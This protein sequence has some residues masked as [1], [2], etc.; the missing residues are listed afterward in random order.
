M[1]VN[2]KPNQNEYSNI[3]AFRFW[4]QK[5]IPLVYEDTLSYYEL[6]SKVVNY[7]NDT[8]K[9]V[10]LMGDDMNKLYTAYTQLHDYVSTYFD[11]LSVQNEVDYKLDLMATDGT[12]S[13]LIQPLFDVYK[14]QIDGIILNQNELIRSE[15]D[16]Q[17]NT[18]DSIDKSCQEQEKSYHVLSGR[19]DTFTSLPNGSTTGDA[20]LLDLR[21]DTDG[22]K[23]NSAGTSVRTQIKKLE[24][25]LFLKRKTYN[26]LDIEKISYPC[27]LDGATGT[28]TESS[29]QDWILNWFTSDFIPCVYG[30]RYILTAY[31]PTNSWNKKNIL[32]RY[33]THIG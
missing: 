21:V 12:L 10:G 33:K 28:T 7:L 19:M 32:V 31:S 29:D 16:K 18:I 26:A 27:F 9:N 17:N 23:H 2:F 1:S 15:F 24:D 3:G 25:S 13:A 6:L 5:V 22:Y 4:C 30:K 11:N 8:I 20:E 14:A